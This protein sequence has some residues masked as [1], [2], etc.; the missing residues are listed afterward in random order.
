MSKLLPDDTIPANAW[1]TQTSAP[2]EDLA[3]PGEVVEGRS[4]YAHAARIVVGSA[5]FGV[6]ILSEELEPGSYGVPSFAD[7]VKSL[8]LLQRHSRLRVLVRKPR[9]AASRSHGLVELA[10]IVTS[11]IEFRE[12]PPDRNPGAAELVIAD[13]RVLL[14]RRGSGDLQGFLY[15]Q[16]PATARERQRTFDALWDESLPSPEFRSLGI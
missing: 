14:E 5:R 16:A 10:R 6:C 9:T 15:T 2:P 1:M 4:A 13:G 7:A 8:V 11:R 3:M 12:L